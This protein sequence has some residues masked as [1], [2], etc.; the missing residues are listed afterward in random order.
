MRALLGITSVPQILFEL[1]MVWAPVSQIQPGPACTF[2]LSLECLPMLFVIRPLP[3]FTRLWRCRI[4]RRCRPLLLLLFL[5]DLHLSNLLSCAHC[6]PDRVVHY[7]ADPWFWIFTRLVAFLQYRLHLRKQCSCPVVCLYRR[8][9][10]RRIQT[11]YI[12]RRL[13]VRILRL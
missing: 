11:I 9:S 3:L 5:F 4:S 8:C 2:P 13:K 7:Q 6:T 10:R 1:Y 12:F